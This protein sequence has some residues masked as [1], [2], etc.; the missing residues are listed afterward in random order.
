MPVIMATGS[1][2]CRGI[3]SDG[4]ALRQKTLGMYHVSIYSLGKAVAVQ[5][6]LANPLS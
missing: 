1:V 3:A 4:I 6:I 2:S 5:V